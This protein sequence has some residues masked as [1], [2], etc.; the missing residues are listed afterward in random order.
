M[1][2]LYRVSVIIFVN[3]IEMPIPQSA[4]DSKG[5]RCDTPFSGDSRFGNVLWNYGGGDRSQNV[6]LLVYCRYVG[7]SMSPKTIGLIVVSA[8]NNALPVP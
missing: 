4:R 7:Y 2:I 5:S 1:Q 6:P 8:P 3:E